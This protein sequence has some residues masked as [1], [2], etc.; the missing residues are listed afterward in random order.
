MTDTAAIIHSP[1]SSEGTENS[2]GKNTKAPTMCEAFSSPNGNVAF[3][4]SDDVVFRVEDYYLKA[5]R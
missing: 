2:T 3:K 1:T 4:S 5:N